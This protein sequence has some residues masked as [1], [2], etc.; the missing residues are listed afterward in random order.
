MVGG[1]DEVVNRRE[2]EGVEYAW[3]DL[4]NYVSNKGTTSLHYV[5]LGYDPGIPG[6]LEGFLV[7][8]VSR[9]E[10]IVAYSTTG[11]ATFPDVLVQQFRLAR[12]IITR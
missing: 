7:D 11:T 2:V 3:S 5:T 9:A 1:V 12:G 10:V 8:G 4:R 6:G